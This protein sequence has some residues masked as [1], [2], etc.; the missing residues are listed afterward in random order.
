MYDLFVWRTSKI[1]CQQ[2]AMNDR[3]SHLYNGSLE[4]TPKRISFPSLRLLSPA[5][6]V[7]TTV[8]GSSVSETATSRAHA[9]SFS[10]WLMSRNKISIG[11]DNTHCY[12]KIAFPS[13]SGRIIFHCIYFTFF[14]P[15]TCWR[16]LRL[17]PCIPHQGESFSGYRLRITYKRTEFISW[18]YM[19][20]GGLPGSY[21]VSDFIS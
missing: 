12:K 7:L 16:V 8:S 1:Y 14:Y 17:L 19:F 15:F 13:F 5:A 3:H 21:L 20:L 11:S 9:V 6:I 18:R 10:V 4:H 2:N